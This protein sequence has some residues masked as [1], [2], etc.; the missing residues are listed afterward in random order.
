MVGGR[1]L[2]G[3]LVEADV[4]RC[5]LIGLGVNVSHASF[6]VELP[7]ATSL[8]IEG[9]RRLDRADLLAHT[10]TRFDEALKDPDAA[11]D[12]YRSLCATIGARVR[13]ERMGGNLEGAA[14]GI[15]PSGALIL[16]VA[17]ED[18]TVQAGDVVHLRQPS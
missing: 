7:G 4:P 6:P 15:D 2:G 12:R 10:M 8:A 13:V 1:K 3:I 5:A 18:V 14:L 16:S 17:G 11:L 9:A